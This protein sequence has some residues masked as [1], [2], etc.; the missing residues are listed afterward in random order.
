[1]ILR[2]VLII[3]FLTVTLSGCAIN[4]VTGKRELRLVPEGSEISMGQK[5]YL[6]SRQMQGGDYLVDPDLVRYVQGVGQRLASVSDRGLPYE[7]AV[8]NDSTPNA[9]ALPGG[10]IAVHRGLLTELDSEAEL[11]AVLGHEIV[12]AA[13]RHGAKGVERG[14]FLQGAVMATQVASKGS[15]LS[16]LVVGGASLAGQLIGQKYGRDA[17]RESDYYGMQ[18][19]VRAGYDPRAAVSLQETFVR[20]AEGRRQDWISGLFSSHPPSQERVELNRQT[21]AALPAGGELGRERYRLKIASL[22]RSKEA[23]EAHDEGRKAISEGRLDEALA[24]AEKAIA[25]E[26]KE[27]FFHSLRGD[28]RTAQERYQEA[29]I[30]YD[31]AVENNDGFFYFLVKRGLV[32]E[33]LGDAQGA[34]ADLEKSLELLPTAPALNV[35]GKLSLDR[36][37]REKAIQYFSAASGSKSESGKEA[38]RSLARLELPDQPDKYLQTRL[39]LDR[40]GYVVAGVA[41]PTELV[42]ADIELVVQFIDAQKRKRQVVLSGPDTLKP[43]A[44]ALVNTGLGPLSDPG[45]LRNFRAGVS[46]ARISD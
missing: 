42:V 19:M 28:V 3:V 44:S 29:L 9:W 16:N 40:D 23:Y 7:F 11:S 6:P 24:L 36:G 31:R 2:I 33:Q 34:Y 12:H 45:L 10:K 46:R 15:D 21:A 39:G 14:I 35:L 38:A 26:P 43:G 41:N 25:I 17:E 1:M 5:Q 4:P 37:D 20:L 27:G 13:A 8:I 18:Y 30:N 32:R 22:I